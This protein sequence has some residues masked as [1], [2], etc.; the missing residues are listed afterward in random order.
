[1]NLNPEENIRWVA[2]RLNTNIALAWANIL[3]GNPKGFLNS[4]LMYLTYG[5]SFICGNACSKDSRDIE[6]LLKYYSG[7]LDK[8]NEI[9][10]PFDDGWRLQ[11]FMLLLKTYVNWLD[12]GYRDVDSNIFG[13]YVVVKNIIKEIT[14]IT[15][16]K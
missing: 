15:G 7:Y 6:N 12:N 5:G 16:E 4:Y 13:D 8:E 11:A 3:T 10:S 2:S 14:E 1:M 9:T